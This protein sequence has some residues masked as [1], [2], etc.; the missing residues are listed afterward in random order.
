MLL[1]A[2]VF[3]VGCS[4]GGCGGCAGMDPIPGGFDVTKRNP[5]ALQ[6]RVAQTALQKIAADPAGVIGPLV[7]TGSMNGVIEF[8]IPASC[9]GDTEIC[10]NN[11]VPATTCGPLLID[12]VTKSPSGAGSE[13]RLTLTPQ[14]GQSRLDA[15]VHTRVKTKNPIKI[16]ATVPLIG[17]KV[18]CSDVS[19]D[20]THSGGSTPDLVLALQLGFPQDATTGTTRINANSVNVNLE[21]DDIQLG[22][23]CSIAQFFIDA[24]VGILADQVSSQIQ[25]T[26]NG[27]TCKPCDSGQVAECN[28]S[29]A[30]ACTDKVCQVGNR[31][32]E[33]LGITGRMRGG[34]VLSSISPGTTGALDLYELLGGY[35]TTDS[36]G[37]ALGMLGGMLPG[38]AQRDRCGPPATA[39]AKATIQPSVF[40]QGNTR[41]DTGAP[42]DVAIGLHKW[43]LDQ[44]AY[45]AY[46]GGF[47]CLTITGNTFAQ[48][49]TDTLSLISRSLGNLNDNNSP[50]AVG[51]RPQ[52]PPTITLGKNTFMDDG[53][54]NKK[55]VEPLLDLKFTQLE[56]DFFASVDDQFIRVFTVVADV[57]LPIGLQTTA[58]GEIQPVIGEIDNAFTNISVKNTDAITESPEQ[59]ASLFPTLLNLVLPQLSGAFSPIALPSLGGLQLQVLGITATPQA[60]GGTDN[61]Y[62]SIFANMAI[63]T[64]I[65]KPVETTVSLGDIARPDLQT[66]KNPKLWRK[67]QEPSVQLSYGDQPGLEYSYR[68]DN[69]TWSAWSTNRTPT[70]KSNVF[71]LPATHTIDVRAREIDK[72]ETIDPTPATLSVDFRGAVATTKPY[73]HGQP[74]QSGCNCQTTNAANASP[75]LLVFAFILLPRRVR[76]RMKKLG[77]TTWLAAIALLPGCSCGSNR[78]GDVDCQPGDVTRGSLG[79]WT[80]I[81]GDDKRVMVATYDQG[82]GDL[83]T[84][85]VTDPTKQK[86]IAVDGVPEDTTAAYEGDYR[87]GIDEPGPN[88]GA[89]TSIAMSN[90]HA[91]VAYQDRDTGDLK[92]AFEKKEGSWT[93]MVVEK[94]DGTTI[95]GQYT[96]IAVDRQGNPAIAYVTSGLDDGMGHRTAE[97]RITRASVK[98]PQNADKWRDPVTVTTQIATCG[99]LCGPGEACVAGMMGETCAAVT[100]D[101]SAACASDEACVAGSCTTAIGE[102]KVSSIGTGTGLFAQL[103]VL[104][105]DRLAVVYYNYFGKQL[106]IA[107]EDAAA[108][109]TFTVTPLDGGAVGDRGPWSRAVVDTAGTVHVAYQDAIADQLM[110]TTWAGQPGTP[111][112]VD[113]GTVAGDRTHPVGA[114]ATI[115]LVGGTPTIAYQDGMT[116]DVYIAQKN[117]AWSTSSLAS[118]PILDGFWVSSTTAHGGAPYLAWGSLDPAATPLGTIAVKQP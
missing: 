34:S 105:D 115:Y 106:E 83:V 21:G 82:L 54:G 73:F 14:Q 64:G 38:G 71:W 26:V 107:V 113:D 23:A 103:L 88:V 30:T 6:M 18:T 48:L 25:D 117:G 111:E 84:I 33:E 45:A 43:Q 102:P 61:S 5:N 27:A 110:Y 94:S 2:A 98:D 53:M 11:G 28:S 8:N 114:G 81:A 93:T 52:S 37:L 99:G 97:L 12:L 32:L 3:A 39:P 78:C 86:F 55:L 46:D 62:L 20:T 66:L 91:M 44:F 24:V 87:D 112:I 70:V 19:I 56:L 29:F 1:T 36:G 60:V 15:T 4:G 118:G 89:F 68:I 67:G 104:P 69:G 80:S 57:E 7:G 72:P 100:A 22:G 42:F 49:S 96:S 76:R 95:A 85:D 31:C 17:T 16:T 59:L 58:M 63:G 79:H 75:L 51:L 109:G 13:P 65:A 10:C 116:A 108:A 47:L 101:C 77:W 74:G 90:H 9:G 41:P 92:F 50:M 35:A 40:F